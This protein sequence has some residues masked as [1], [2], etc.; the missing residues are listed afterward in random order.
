MFTEF[1]DMHSGGGLKTDYHYWYVE[2]AEPLARQVFTQITGRDPDNVTCHCCG[3]DYSV[4]EYETL[5]EATEFH[6][7]NSP[8]TRT[9][10]GDWVYDTMSL[11]EYL[12]GDEAKVVYANEFPFISEE[13]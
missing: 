7:R 8:Y 9:P 3:Q 12:L 5:E 13:D 6:R 1:W 10:D 2:A 4:T 11:A